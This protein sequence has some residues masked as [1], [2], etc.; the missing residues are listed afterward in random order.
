LIE[1]AMAISPDNGAY[2]DSYGWVYYRMGNFDLALTE[3]QK[4]AS[5]INSDPIIFEHLGDVYKALGNNEKALR[6]YNRA[7]EIDPDSLILEE[8]LR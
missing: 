2:I 1:K 5:L 7:L 6:Y 4:A 3:L 8:K